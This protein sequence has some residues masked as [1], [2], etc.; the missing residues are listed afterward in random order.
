MQIY[1]NKRKET[2]LYDSKN[3]R[4]ETWLLQKCRSR[5]TAWV[6]CVDKAA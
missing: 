1:E 3:V 6:G 5:A 4:N 2:V